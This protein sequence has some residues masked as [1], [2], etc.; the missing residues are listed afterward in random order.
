MTKT[1][2]AAALVAAAGLL[3]AAG[4]GS[5]ALASSGAPS[6]A[7]SPGPATFTAQAYTPMRITAA[8][9]ITADDPVPSR[10]FLDP[11]VLVDP[12]N[13]K[14]MVAATV[15]A[16][17]RVCYLLRSTDGGTTW[18]YLANKP[19]LP[20]YPFCFVPSG[21]ITE[22]P[23]AWGRNHTLY[24]GLV[25]Y[26]DEDG[27]ATSKG[28]LSTMVARSTD[29]GNTWTTTLVSN[30]RGKTGTAIEADAPVVSI[31]VDTS[32]P[33][34][35]VYLGYR[36][37]F[38]NQPT[39]S[40]GS[41]VSVST[42][43]GTTFGPPVNLNNSSST[44]FTDTKTGK[45]QPIY[46]G[47]PHVAA[48]AKGA[49][50]AVAGGSAPTGTTGAPPQP[51]FVGASGDRGKTWTM[52]AVTPAGASA[53]A[54]LWTPQG[55]PEGTLLVSYQYKVG[56]TQGNTDI[57]LQRST[58][59]GRTWSN[60]ARLNDDNPDNQNYHLF[61]AMSAAPDGRIDVVWYD[62]RNAQSFADDVYYTYS[63]DHGATWAPNI[64]ATDQLVDR[65]LGL[66]NN[67]DVRQPPSVGSSNQAAVVGWSDTR[68]GDQ[69]TD[70]QDNFASVVQFKTFTTTSGNKVLK[71]LAAAAAGLAIA[72]LI[73]VL[74]ALR[75][76]SRGRIEPPPA[77]TDRQ[78]QSVGVS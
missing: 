47:T 19:T 39:A 78:R 58:D 15:E 25:G 29:L 48:G 44:S 26:S 41:M 27:G 49:V 24:Y 75:R 36:Q 33:K 4:G 74:L 9:Q 34:D 72:G 69:Q 18:A 76:R 20:S 43:G 67:T 70:T 61:P 60:P 62:F 51:L 3:A 30:N 38:P 10:T 1:G 17:S 53:S 55:G 42:D 68:L 46:Y 2:R 11:Y 22:S 5:A 12:D 14:V 45:T 65:N 54:I 7:S 56:Q 66:N 73:V 8:H 50:W 59:G 6:Q 64:R 23:I 16:R 13:S 32:G 63:T 37:G 31:A 40:R 52:R 35:T 28:N 77:S 57:Y 71:Y 21:G